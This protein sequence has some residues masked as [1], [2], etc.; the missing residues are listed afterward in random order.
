MHVLHLISGLKS[1]GAEGV[2]FKLIKNDKNNKHSIIAFSGGFYL[3]KLKKINVNVSLIQLNKFS[4]LFKL[5]K[6]INIIKKKILILYNHGC[7]MRIL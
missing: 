1:G 7:I 6:I 2:L 3:N 4:F 5:P